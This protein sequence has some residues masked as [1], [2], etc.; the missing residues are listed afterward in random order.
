MKYDGKII[1]QAGDDTTF[2]RQTGVRRLL[3]TDC[4]NFTSKDN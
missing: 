3:D 2:D 1:K 4:S